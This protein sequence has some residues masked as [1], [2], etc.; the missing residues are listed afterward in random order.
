VESDAREL[1]QVVRQVIYSKIVSTAQAP[2]LAAVSTA[3]GFDTGDVAAAVRALADLHIIVLQPGTTE[4]WSAPPFSAVPTSFRVRAD[5]MSWYA[6]CAWDS[7][8]IPAALNRSAVIDARCAWSGDPLPALVKNGRV[9][10][11][12]VVHLEVPARRFWDDIFYT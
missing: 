9:A 2:T 8:G 10:G 3:T 11:S 4:V 7:F 5:G 6:P 12:G 1:L